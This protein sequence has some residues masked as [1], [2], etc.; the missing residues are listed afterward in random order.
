MAEGPARVGVG[1]ESSVALHAIH[2]V[3]IFGHSFVRRLREHSVEHKEFNLRLDPGRFRLIFHGI[4][5]M[6]L[7][8][9]PDHVD[10]VENLWP[11]SIILD[12]GANDLDHVSCPDPLV[13][14]SRI[15]QFAE[16]L[17]SRA[18]SAKITV[19]M[20]YPRRTPRRVDYND[21]SVLRAYNTSLKSQAKKHPHIQVKPLNN[22]MENWQD[23]VGLDGVHFNQAGME[24]YACNIRRACLQLGSGN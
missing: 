18:N 13:T 9:A 22:M 14:A 17:R 1:D 3:V 15:I 21:D 6:T 11:K 24:R 2:D 23:F 8:S 10:V 20:A 5:G 4:G 19:L 7:K 16:D 12:L